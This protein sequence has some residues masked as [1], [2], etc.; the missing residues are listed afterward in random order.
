MIVQVEEREYARLLGYPWG[1][2]LDGKVRERA[3][4][5]VQW[6]RRNGNPRVYCTDVTNFRD[7]SNTQSPLLGEGGVAAPIKK[8]PRSDPRLSKEP[9][10]HFLDGASTPPSPRRGDSSSSPAGLFQ[11]FTVAALT[12]GSEV[13]TEVS[14]L[15]DEGRVDE[16]YFL[17]RYAAGV[18]EALASQ[19]GPYQSPG[20][21]RMP[22]EEQWTLFSYIAPLRPEIEM[23]PSGMLRP[24]NSLLAI[25]PFDAGAVSNPCTRCD[26]AGCTF[27]RRSA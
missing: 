14:R 27:R 9:S 5:A 1:T 4:Q 20:T 3:H 2:L 22:F 23:L 16:A 18:V 6:Y 19:L 8:M 24:K 25:V 21:G 13:D 11:Q 7:T 15:W 26:L 17:D 10:G 12:A